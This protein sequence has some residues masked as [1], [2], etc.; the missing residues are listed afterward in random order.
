MA[1]TGQHQWLHEQDGAPAA[2]A[3]VLHNASSSAQRQYAATAR[4]SEPMAS[5]DA[6]DGRGPAGQDTD[7]DRVNAR[8]YGY[9]TLVEPQTPTKTTP[10]THRTVTSHRRS[11]SQSQQSQSSYRSIPN[12]SKAADTHRHQPSRPQIDKLSLDFICR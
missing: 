6:A 3:Y 5:M 12:A 2:A 10:Y 1:W 4:Q 9:Q 8:R 11:P 7:T